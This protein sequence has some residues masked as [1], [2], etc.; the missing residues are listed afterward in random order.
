MAAALPDALAVAAAVVDGEAPV[1]RVAVAVAVAVGASE[2]DAAVEAERE[3]EMEEDCEALAVRDALPLMLPLMLP[4]PLSV[5]VLPLPP[6]PLADGDQLAVLQALA[7]PDELDEALGDGASAAADCVAASEGEALAEGDG[8]APPALPL[9][10]CVDEALRE[11]V[12]LSVALPVREHEG[13]AL[14]EA[15]PPPLL[16][17]PDAER[18]GEALG[19]ALVAVREAVPLPLPT[20]PAREA[21]REALGE[22]LPPPGL[23]E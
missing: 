10:D 5:G 14:T 15:P 20:L 18:D 22:P 8:A 19:D 4:L 2:G 11:R 9:R 13:E 12:A 7:L 17:E 3:A 1:D 6:L 23:A 16:E 21:E